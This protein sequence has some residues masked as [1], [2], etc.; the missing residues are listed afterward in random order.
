MLRALQSLIIYLFLVFVGS[1]GTSKDRR[2][3]FM[4]LEDGMVIDSVFMKENVIRKGDQLAITV[5]SLN[6]K[7]DALIA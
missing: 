5:A 7:F 2:Q 4:G 3:Y 6:P 1:C